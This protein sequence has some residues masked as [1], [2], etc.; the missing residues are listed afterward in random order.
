[1]KEIKELSKQLAI[2][3]IK[4]SGSRTNEIERCCWI[5]VHEFRHGV[6]PVEYDIRD[7]DEDLY[8]TVL[9]YAKNNINKPS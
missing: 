7:I 5:V 9:N 8:L 4:L 6:K 3:A 1:M 2:K